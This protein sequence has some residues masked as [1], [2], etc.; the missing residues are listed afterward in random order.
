M[1]SLQ[2]LLR[3]FYVLLFLLSIYSLELH[4]SLRQLEDYMIQEEVDGGGGLALSQ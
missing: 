4:L 1:M 2:V 3:Q